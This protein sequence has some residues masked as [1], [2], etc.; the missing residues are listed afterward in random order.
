[1]KV[2][3]SDLSCKIVLIWPC[4]MDLVVSMSDGT[5]LEISVVCPL[6]VLVG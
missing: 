5:V 4:F 3:L 1:M 6:I 2:A